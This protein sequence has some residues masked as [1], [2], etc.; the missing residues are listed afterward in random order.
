MHKL[1]LHFGMAPPKDLRISIKELQ[2]PNDFNYGLSGFNIEPYAS[3]T[4]DSI[5]NSLLRLASVLQDR[6]RY[7]Q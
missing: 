4:N 7:F 3:S 6:V 2:R 5:I 1:Y